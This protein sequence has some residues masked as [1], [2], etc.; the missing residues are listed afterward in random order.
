MTGTSGLIPVDYEGKMAV[1]VEVIKWIANAYPRPKVDIVLASP[2]RFLTS[3]IKV[4]LRDGSMVAT[5]E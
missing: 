4:Y 2:L 1:P 5:P 3:L